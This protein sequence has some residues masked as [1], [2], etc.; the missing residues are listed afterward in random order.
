MLRTF[1]SPIFA[2]KNLMCL[3]W[4]VR[5]A[6]KLICKCGGFKEILL[7]LTFHDFQVQIS[8]LTSPSVHICYSLL[9][10]YMLNDLLR[11]SLSSI[12]GVGIILLSQFMPWMRRYLIELLSHKC[13]KW[14]V[15]WI[16]YNVFK[17]GRQK[18]NLKV[19][20]HIFLIFLSYIIKSKMKLSSVIKS[21]KSIQQN[22]LTTCHYLALNTVIEIIILKIYGVEIIV[23]IYMDL[24]Y[25]RYHSKL[26]TCITLFNPCNVMGLWCFQ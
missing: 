11:N 9:C 5:R 23:A 3:Y 24:L 6:A 1:I 20:P 8:C 10:K 15:K 22:L 16:C 2:F 17:S 4:N 19:I 13:F 18:P 7:D 26:N 21:K 25:I 12:W 14:K